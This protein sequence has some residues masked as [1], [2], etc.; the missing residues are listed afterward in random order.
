MERE[1]FLF[2]SGII[3]FSIILVINIFKLLKANNQLIKNN[4]IWAIGTDIT[5]IL[6]M[7][8]GLLGNMI[9]FASMLFITIIVAVIRHKKV[10]KA[11]SSET[12]EIAANVMGKK[13]TW[14]DFFTYNGLVKVATKFGTAKTALISFST[15]LLILTMLHII[16]NI[17]LDRKLSLLI[18]IINSLTLSG[19]NT[20]AF[21][22]ILKRS[23]KNQT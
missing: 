19:L 23:I 18:I 16:A 20:I 12:V 2:I 11:Q 6:A 1:L 21:Y 3:F 15:G 9:I 22:R 8:S 13:L 10:I 7:I 14:M 5:L 4:Y 17:F